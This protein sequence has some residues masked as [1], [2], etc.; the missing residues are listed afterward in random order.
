MFT[1]CKITQSGIQIEHTLKKTIN[2]LF[3]GTIQTCSPTQ[4]AGELDE[5]SGDV[6][7]QTLFRTF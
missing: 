4:F 1:L 7:Y 3:A 2:T 6:C 5:I